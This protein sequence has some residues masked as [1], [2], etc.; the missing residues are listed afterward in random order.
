MAVAVEEQHRLTVVGDDPAQWLIKS[1]FPNYT[2]EQ[3]L[4]FLDLYIRTHRDEL[5]PIIL[6]ALLYS[7]NAYR[8]EL[9]GVLISVDEGRIK[10]KGPRGRHA[11]KQ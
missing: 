11:P 2:D 7:R 1:T 6:E 5:H 10:G 8:D 9:A 3:C 4:T